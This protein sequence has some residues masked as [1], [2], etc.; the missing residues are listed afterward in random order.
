[1][2]LKELEL[3]EFQ[4]HAHLKLTFGPGVNYLYGASDAGKSCIRRA[5]GFLYFGD[6]RTDVI[7]REGS[8]QTSVRAVMNDDIEV[9]RIKSSSINRYIIRKPNC[10]ELVF[11]SIG[12]SIPEEVQKI[13]QVSTLNIDDKEAPLNLNIEKQITLPFLSDRSPS[14]RN[15]LFNRL[16]G[17]D[18]LDKLIQNLNKEMLGIGRDIKAAQEFIATN[19]PRLQEVTI[20]HSDKAK[21]LGNFQEKREVLLKKVDQYKKLVDLQTRLGAITTGLTQTQE[22]LKV[23]KMVPQE[24]IN[25]LHTMIDSW[26]SFTD[27]KEALEA[28][29]TSLLEAE[30]ALKGIKTP[31]MDIHT[32]RVQ[33]D[34]LKALQRIR[35]GFG[36][37]EAGI[38]E[39][40]AM[41]QRQIEQ[42]GQCEE[43]YST[44]LKEAGVCPV[45]KQDTTKCQ[46]HS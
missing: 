15:K 41:L 9:E 43:K 26:I 39:K 25:S 20:Q 29:K 1:M 17:N 5:I 8:K 45:C 18:L 4:K 38:K 27:L 30:S 21:V 34:R 44:L 6:P 36:D 13:L 46:V 19:E 24:T 10:K 28:N 2:W 35:E 3:F 40:Q 33:I 14:F 12:A 31:E 32:V 23:I 7:R 22:A 37:L 42:I 11:D 16:T